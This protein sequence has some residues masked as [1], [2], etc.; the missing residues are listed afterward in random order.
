LR[1][2]NDLFGIEAY[3]A[4]TGLDGPFANYQGLRASALHPWL[5]YCAPLGQ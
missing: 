1:L 3:L 4:L 2:T 5:F